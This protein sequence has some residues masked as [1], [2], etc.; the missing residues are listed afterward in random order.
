MLRRL[1]CLALLTGALLAASCAKRETPAEEGIRTRTLLVGN[2]AEPASLDPNLIDAYTDMNLAVAL[3]EGLTVLD[4][5]TSAALPGVADHWEISPDG[6]VYTF[7]L[8]PTAQWSNG[9]PV[10]ADDFAYSFQRILSPDFAASY[11]YMLWPIRNAEAFNSCKLKDFS[12]VGVAVLD[13]HTLRITLDRPTPYL[14]ALA[15]HNTWMP[16]PRGTVEKFGR[17]QDRATAWTRPGNLVSNGPFTLTEWQP[18]SRIIV[19]KNARYWDAAHNHLERVIF[20]PTEQS[21]TEERNFRAG[22]VHLTYSVPAAKI[23]VYQQTAPGSLRLDPLLSQLFVNFNTTRA[24]LNNPKVRR[25][26]S[27]AI[28]RAAICRSVYNGS[29]LPA[30]SFTPPGCGGYVPPEPVR[31]DYDAARALLAEAGYPGGRGLPSLPFQVLNDDKTPKIAEALQAMWE[32]ELGVHLTIEPYEQKT[33]LQNQQSL[34]FTV[35]IQGWTADFPD[36]IT[37]LGTFTTGNGNNW[38]G[39]GSRAYDALIAQ[40]SATA[41]PDARFALFQ[42]AES[43][44]LGESPIAPLMFGSRSYLIHPAVKNWQPAPLGLHRYQVVELQ[45]P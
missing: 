34:N 33:L 4:E 31:L 16:V 1:P 24:P 37:F 8:R 43:L 17:M 30:A 45:A 7:H 5:R 32:K 25:A 14:L 2:L 13:A 20:F 41:D 26:L 21:D 29:R 12:A 42:Q 28:D 19:T 23:P 3:F 38:T 40:A 39:W 27:L 6:L 15:A 10:T 35:A 11:S 44:L 36:P 9:D 22:Q 18:N